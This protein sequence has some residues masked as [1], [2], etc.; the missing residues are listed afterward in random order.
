[1]VLPPGKQRAWDIL[2][3]PLRSRPCGGEA[4]RAI[5]DFGLGALAV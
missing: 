5:L 2:H 4:P 1:M 3:N